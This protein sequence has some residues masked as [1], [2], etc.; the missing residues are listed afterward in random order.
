MQL[1]TDLGQVRV[2]KRAYAIASLLSFEGRVL[3][4][5]N[6]TILRD[7]WSTFT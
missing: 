3:D 2:L 1:I 5:R 4:N 7:H 6:F